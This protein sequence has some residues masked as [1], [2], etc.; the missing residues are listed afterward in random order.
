MDIFHQSRPKVSESIVL[1]IEDVFAEI[2]RFLEFL[3]TF[4][5]WGRISHPAVVIEDY[6][7]DVKLL[8]ACKVHS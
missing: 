8:N 3:E 2:A 4:Q 5:R 7:V 6:L 1:M